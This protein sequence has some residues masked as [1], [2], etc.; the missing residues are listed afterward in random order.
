MFSVIKKNGLVRITLVAISL[1]WMFLFSEFKN[2]KK[3]MIVNDI[4]SY[5]GYLPAIFIF[6]DI[7]LH[8]E[9]S[10]KDLHATGFFSMK[11]WPETAPNGGRVIKT[12]M[13]L[14][15]LY[16]PFFFM[17]HISAKYLN[18]TSLGYSPPYY[19]FLNLSCFFYLI[20]GLFFLGRLLRIYFSEL[21]T[22]L[23]LIVVFFGTNLF[24]YCTADPLL[25]HSY[26]F[27]LSCIFLYLTVKW[28]NTPNLW[29]SLLLGLIGG[30]LTIIRP[31]NLILMLV[32]V[33]FNIT[34]KSQ[35]IS[36]AV[37]FK[38]KLAYIFVVLLFFVIPIF[39]QLLYWKYM[40]G[41]WLFNSYVGERFYFSH[42]HIIEI[43]FSYRKG[44]LLYTPLM[45][46][47]LLGFFLLKKYVPAFTF[48]II[49]PFLILLYV[50]SSWWCW[51]YGGSFGSRPFVDLY[52]LLAI[53]LA[54]TL[55]YL[56]EKKIFIKVISFAIILFLITLNQVQCYQYKIGGLIH[57][58]G[59]TKESYWMHFMKLNP[60]PGWWDAI[61]RPDYDNARKG[62]PEKL[63]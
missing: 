36:K 60:A 46:L 24:F 16:A 20:L 63:S 6:D 42:P 59:N 32:P 3:E 31:T 21:I 19:F 56:S 8:F 11:Y 41:Q 55:R 13:G 57:W 29:N 58:D 49:L 37:F 30:L 47:S 14:S 34:D 5:Y 45:T 28:N 51:W 50:I 39:P 17:G 2:W 48:A 27:S 4:V 43:L 35:A 10:Q 7:T 38:E 52:G 18:Y 44:W 40:T 61:Q 26:L 53:P 12:T 22:S 62:L 54:C 9:T 23:T 15:Y 25:A 1:I 33:L